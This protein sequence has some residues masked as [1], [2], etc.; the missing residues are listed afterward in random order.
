METEVKDHRTFS[1]NTTDDYIHIYGIRV[2]KMYK[3]PKAPIYNV[4]SAEKADLIFTP[5]AIKSIYLRGSK[6]GNLRGTNE[7]D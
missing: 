4:G 5:E 6:E 3:Y 1:E 7:I 2:V